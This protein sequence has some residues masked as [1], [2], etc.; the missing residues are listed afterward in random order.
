MPP[1]SSILHPLIFIGHT[2][3]IYSSSLETF[4]YLSHV[5]LIH[6]FINIYSIMFPLYPLKSYQTSYP[7]RVYR[8]VMLIPLQRTCWSY[9]C[10]CI[11]TSTYLYHCICESL[12]IKRSEGRAK[13][14]SEARWECLLQRWVSIQKNSIM[15]IIKHRYMN[16]IDISL[17]SFRFEAGKKY[18]N[19]YHVTL[20]H[21]PFLEIIMPLFELPVFN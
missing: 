5:T 10:S 17:N 8:T 18:W 19:I 20:Q 21:E 4:Y 7:C 1:H 14:L 12:K 6:H 2:Q 16:W 9:L 11:L 13:A 15:G 3:Y